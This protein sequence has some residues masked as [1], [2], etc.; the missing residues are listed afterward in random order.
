MY[1]TLT[2]SLKALSSIFA[3]NTSLYYSHE[4]ITQYTNINISCGHSQALW[5]KL[6]PS[7]DLSQPTWEIPPPTSKYRLPPPPLTHTTLLHPLSMKH[8][9]NAPQPLHISTYLSDASAKEN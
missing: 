5:S 2:N 4:S 7:S 1:I 9:S 3:L 8:F 6:P